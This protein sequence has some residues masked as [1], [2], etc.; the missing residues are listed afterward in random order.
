MLSIADASPKHDGNYTCHA[1]NA[2]ASASYTAPLHVDGEETR[3]TI[4]N[5][6]SSC[7]LS[8]FL[9]YFNFQYTLDISMSLCDVT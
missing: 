3:A 4:T 9:R 2:A 1:N 6:F 8:S 7:L 5:S